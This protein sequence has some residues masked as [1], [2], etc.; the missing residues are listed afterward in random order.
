MPA[1]WMFNR[2]ARYR[3][4]C[5]ALIVDRPKREIE[6]DDDHEEDWLDDKSCLYYSDNSL[7][8]HA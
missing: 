8:K 6:Y 5:R 7:N 1:L 3:Y 4:R 2:R